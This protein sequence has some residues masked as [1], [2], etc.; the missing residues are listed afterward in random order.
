MLRFLRR[1]LSIY[2]VVPFITISLILVP[3]HDIS[4][5]HEVRAHAKDHYR[6]SDNLQKTAAI[7]KTHLVYIPSKKTLHL[8][9]NVLDRH[10]DIEGNLRL[11][12]TVMNHNPN[13]WKIEGE[14]LFVDV[15]QLLA[16]PETDLW[17]RNH[18]V[19]VKSLAEKLQGTRLQVIDAPTIAAIWYY[20][21]NEI[22]DKWSDSHGPYYAT[23][24][25][26]YNTGPYEIQC[27]WHFSWTE[28]N[29]YSGGAS[30][31]TSHLEVHFG[32]EVTRQESRTT[33]VICTLQPGWGCRP[34]YIDYHNHAYNAYDVY[35]CTDEELK[36]QVV[37]YYKFRESASGTE[38]HRS[39]TI[40][41]YRL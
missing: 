16:L 27:A 6:I 37:C 35:W 12:L 4:L 20:H 18:L 9:K 36:G 15:W 28:T 41:Y 26:C 14:E 24:D 40:S 10:L 2:M 34:V 17:D 25:S 31:P 8:Q 1:R 33:T 32:F 30:V 38:H 11:F 29:T 3:M 39:Y 7:L 5:A 19:L 21:T 23:N 13:V 22:V